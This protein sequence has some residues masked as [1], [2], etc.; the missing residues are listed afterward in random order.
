MD[1]LARNRKFKLAC[2]CFIVSS[3]A[4]FTGNM[5]GGEYVAAITLILGLYN[6][7]NINGGKDES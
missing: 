7:A 4:L 6:Y 1:I 2:G 5:S 3:V